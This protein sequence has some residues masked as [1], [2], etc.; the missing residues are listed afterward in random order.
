MPAGHLLRVAHQHPVRRCSRHRI[1]GLPT[2][3]AVIAYEP[4]R[5]HVTFR[6]NQHP[7]AADHVRPGHDS[8]S[9]L[10]ATTLP[11]EV[12][13]IV[14]V[15]PEARLALRPRLDEPAAPTGTRVRQASSERAGAA[16]NEL[17][18]QIP[19]D[20]V[21]S[22]TNASQIHRR[23]VPHAGRAAT[24]NLPDRRLCHPRR[25]GGI[26]YDADHTATLVIG[27]AAHPHPRPLDLV[28]R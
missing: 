6:A 16:S 7:H 21:R 12:D 1:A 9:G 13:R 28:V 18:H 17:C 2:C 23:G 15:W 14:A 8:A 24:I 26:R 27:H 11:A 10:T 19:R 5:P 4:G 22:I 25:G 3:E 20:G